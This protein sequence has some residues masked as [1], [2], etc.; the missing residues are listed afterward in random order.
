M[1]PAQPNLEH[2]PTDILLEI[3]R[4]LDLKDVLRLREVCG[5]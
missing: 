3:A 2:C 1:Q 5:P 4:Y